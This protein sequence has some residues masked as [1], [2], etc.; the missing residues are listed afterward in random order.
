[1][2]IGIYVYN[3]DYKPIE[4]KPPL[5]V[6]PGIGG[7][8]YEALAVGFYISIFYPSEQIVF[9]T[10]KP[11]SIINMPNI[12]NIVIEN[13]LD[14][15]T[16]A[17][18]N[19]IDVFLMNKHSNSGFCDISDVT[20]LIDKLE[21]KTI[22]IGQCFYSLK[23]CDYISN[24]K[25]IGLNAF[26]SQQ[27]FNYY[28]DHPIAKKSTYIY[29]MTNKTDKNYKRAQN[30]STKKIV[31]YLGS[32]TDAKGF[33]LLAQEWKEIIQKVPEAELHVIGSGKLYDQNAKLGS[34][35]IADQKYENLFIPYL[36]NK[37]GTLLD[38]V[39][40]HG[41]LSF[42]EMLPILKETSVGVVNPGGITETFCISAIE[43]EE[44][45][46][47]VVTR[48]Y[49]GLIDTV[50]DNYS[51]FL[52]NSNKTLR[53]RI[54]ALLNNVELNK[55]MGINGVDYVNTNF[56]PEV[57]IPK[58][59]ESINWVNKNIGSNYTKRTGKIIKIINMIKNRCPPVDFEEDYCMRSNNYK[60][61]QIPQR[62]C[63][64]FRLYRFYHKCIKRDYKCE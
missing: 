17:K 21:L 23:E 45:G 62:K 19:D 28:L 44:F 60:V 63:I 47:P 30:F 56:I 11:L 37:D 2:K 1:M 24:C 61:F 38:S 14:A 6:N 12:Q 52:V 46:I 41:T 35:N 10:Q 27:Q 9:F 29:N 5:L 13:I 50:K 34:F 51:G 54:I 15:C 58:W 42:S 32:L 64:K 4:L 20:V 22:T 55:T 43:L 18:N 53:Q 26:V 48:R 8:E 40:F 39:H 59:M 49:G 33:H 57:I 25:H 3:K 31:T 36:Q 7:S 16:E